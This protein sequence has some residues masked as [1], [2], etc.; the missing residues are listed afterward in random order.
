MKRSIADAAQPTGDPLR[1]RIRTWP[2]AA[3]K[4]NKFT[5]SQQLFGAAHPQRWN[6][7]GRHDHVAGPAPAPD[8]GLAQEPHLVE[9]GGRGRT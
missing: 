3:E 7:S 6:G 5:I 2:C 1:L 4:H 9:R 8:P